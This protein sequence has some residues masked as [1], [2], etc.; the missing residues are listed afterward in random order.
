MKRPRFPLGT[1]AILLGFVAASAILA[2]LGQ[3]PPEPPSSIL[4]EK[5]IAY[6][7][8]AGKPLLL[9]LARPKT[10]TRHKVAWP[11][12]RGYHAGIVLGESVQSSDCASR[13]A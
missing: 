6:S 2:R 9:D 8:V 13:I 7:N 4:F 12:G 5:D 1:I 10:G 3:S 11:P